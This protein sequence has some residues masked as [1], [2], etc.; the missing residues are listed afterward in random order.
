MENDGA[1]SFRRDQRFQG[2]VLAL[3]VYEGTINGRRVKREIVEHP[4]AAAV[5]AVKGDGTVVMVNQHRFPHGNVLEIPAGTLE[6]GESPLECAR[7]ELREET[8]YVADSIRPLLS[9]Y[10]SVGYNTEIIHCFVATGLSRTESDPD[11][12]EIISVEEHHIKEI[13]RMIGEGLIRDSKTICAAL[14]FA[15]YGSPTAAG[16]R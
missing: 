14:A 7:R 8:G 2:R 5:L 9:F 3:S 16:R 1:E 15:Q 6:R 13:T 10:P 4:G 11:E 12:D